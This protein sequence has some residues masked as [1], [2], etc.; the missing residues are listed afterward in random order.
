MLIRIISALVGAPLIIFFLLVKGNYLYILAGL[1]SLVGLY[2]Y[3]KA[4]RTVGIKTIDIIG[5]I[6]CIAYYIILFM[7][8]NADILGYLTASM[9][10]VAFSYE[11]FTRKSGVNG[12][13]HT[14]FGFMYVSYLLSH[15][16]LVNRLDN[17][18]ILVWL[19][20][21][22]AW[23]T[24]TA[25][26]FTGVT[27]GKHK[28]FPTISPKK[29]VEGYIGGTIGS[30][31]LTTAFG[32]IVGSYGSSIGIMNFVIIG[33]I[34]AIASELGDLVSSYIKR[35]AG[36]KDFGN[37]IPGHGGILD[38]FDSILFTAPVVYYFFLIIQNF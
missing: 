36:I 22:T 14:I 9:I 35:Y 21:V 13:V 1:L 30:I 18:D 11:I 23:F 3:Y 12:V 19:P 17:G 4:M 20:F 15:I 16:I 27:I 34:C 26:Y 10:I 28:A 37:L 2:E 38:R 31:L 5:Y 24:D 29:T 33:F 8:P 25:A 7:Y 6:Y 32:L